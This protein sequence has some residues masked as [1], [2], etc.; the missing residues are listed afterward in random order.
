MFT[1]WPEPIWI[2][3]KSSWQILPQHQSS[4]ILRRWNHHQRFVLCSNGQIY[5]GDFAKFCGLLRIYELYPKGPESAS[6]EIPP[7]RPHFIKFSKAVSY[8]LW[9][10]SYF[11]TLTF[12]GTFK[13]QL[14]QILVLLG[15][16]FNAAVV[17]VTSH[18]LLF[19]LALA[20]LW[21]L[22]NSLSNIIS[23]N[24]FLLGSYEFLEYMKG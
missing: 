21:A 2:K 9:S 10:K 7:F 16:Y 24:V 4:Y 13:F 5:G 15:M 20:M 12:R 8:P 6:I 14:V 1:V 17:F 18:S 3:V 11:T 22:S 19:R 23:K